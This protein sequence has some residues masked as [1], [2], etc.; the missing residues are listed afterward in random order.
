MSRREIF[1]FS[2]QRRERERVSA[3]TTGVSVPFP[4]STLC[5]GGFIIVVFVTYVK[6]HTHKCLAHSRFRAKYVYVCIATMV[7]MIIV[8]YDDDDDDDD[9]GDD[10]TSSSSVVSPTTTAPPTSP[11]R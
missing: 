4:V 5:S 9:D 1:F 6:T 11:R 8:I 2:P 10:M 3:S 7:F